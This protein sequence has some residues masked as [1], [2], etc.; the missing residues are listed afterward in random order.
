MSSAIMLSLTIMC[1]KQ[2]FV[3]SASEA[4]ARVQ[5]G[6]AM[7][8]LHTTLTVSTVEYEEAETEQK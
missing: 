3:L 4:L 2:E 8:G 7:E 1:E 5:A 6:L